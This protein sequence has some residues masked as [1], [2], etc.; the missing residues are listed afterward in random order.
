[1]PRY[2][3]PPLVQVWLAFEF[4]PSPDKKKWDLDLVEEFSKAN[5]SEYPT[6]EAQ[7]REELK[8]ESSKDGNLPRIVDRRETIDLVRMTSK[9]ETRIRHLGDDRIAFNLLSKDTGY[10]G[11]EP[12]LQS[13]VE[14]LQQYI[15]Q[16]QPA[17]VREASIHHTD[18][19]E[20]PS[21][22]G[23]LHL[24]DYF[25]SIPD[26]PV[27]P[28]GYTVGFSYSFSAKCPADQKLLSVHLKLIPPSEPNVLRVQV[29]WDKKC[30]GFEFS[31][32]ENAKADLTASHE[33]MVECFEAFI[34]DNTRGLFGTNE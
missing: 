16:F 34:T 19:I 1:M 14:Y 3:N 11:F 9:D 5:E 12:L 10:L 30:Q 13:G 31:G 28:F 4:D 20:I 7:F 33:Y 18:L 26:V 23:K 17:R 22:D 21:N 6:V 2:K 25:N 29:D 32:L 24:P 27:E 15:S 8:V